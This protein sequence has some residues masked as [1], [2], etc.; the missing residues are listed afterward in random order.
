MEQR[1]SCVLV[2]SLADLVRL[3]N[4]LVPGGLRRCLEC[5]GLESV[6][7]K[8]SAEPQ[9]W[10]D[11]EGGL[12][13]PSPLMSFHAGASHYISQGTHTNS[14]YVCNHLQ[15]REKD[16]ISWDLETRQMCMC[17]HMC[18]CACVYVCEYDL[19]EHRGGKR[20]KLNH[21]QRPHKAAS[22]P[23][24]LGLDVTIGSYSQS[25]LRLIHF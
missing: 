13:S 20:K 22:R 10:R 2:H 6:C 16:V 24:I 4:I 15:R 25:T 3:L 8:E 21:H 14:L 7:S 11:P 18:V 17:A 23:P 1:F 9:P 5:P 19:A 12:L